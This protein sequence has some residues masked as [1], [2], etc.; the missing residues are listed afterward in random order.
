MVEQ[1]IIDE[2][3]KLTNTERLTIIEIALDMI[4]KDLKQPERSCEFNE[5]RQKMIEAAKLL[6]ADYTTD[7]ELTA[8]I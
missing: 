7:D 3:K 2:L 4:R 6:L 5:K 1:K 8:F